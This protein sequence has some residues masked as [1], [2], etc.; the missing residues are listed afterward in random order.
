MKFPKQKFLQFC[1]RLVIDSK[2]QGLTPLKLNGAQRF[3]I[4]SMCASLEQ[5]VHKFVTLK[6][7]QFGAST[8]MLALDLFWQFYYQGM[9]GAIVVDKEKTR[10]Q[11]KS[12]LESYMLGLPREWRIPVRQHNRNQLVLQNRSRVAYLVAGGRQSG[13]LA[14]GAGLNFLHA[15]EVSS[16]SDEEGLA[17]LT[18]S[19]AEKHPNRLY[20]FESTARGFNIFYDMWQDALRSHSTKGIFIGWWL[21]EDYALDKDS[22]LFD[23]YW[24]GKLSQ[25]ERRWVK[26]VK[27]EHEFDIRPEQIAWYRW[28]LGEEIHDEKLMMQEFPWLPDQAFIL[29]GEQFFNTST[30]L[31][32]KKQIDVSP[33]PETFSYEIGPEFQNTQLHAARDGELKIWQQPA[34]DGYYAIGADPAYGGSESGDNFVIQ[35]LRCYADGVE[36]V[37]EYASRSGTM[38]G[39][40]WILAHLAGAY[41]NVHIIL[42]ITGPGNGVW[43]ELQTLPSKLAYQNASEAPVGQ[44]LNIFGNMSHYIYRRPDSMGGG[45]GFWH[46]QTTANNKQWSMHQ[47]RDA[48]ERKLLKVRSLD[49]IDEARYITQDGSSISGEGR[50]KDDRV[51]G[52]ALAVEAWVRA[53]QPMLQAQGRTRKVAGETAPDPTVGNLLVQGYLADLMAG[54]RPN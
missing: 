49:W 30:L 26:Q 32:I 27:V 39:F 9:Q 16:W 31:E 54:K 8:V 11:F 17:S 21:K 53:V 29:S 13:A 2:E 44:L 15:T 23:V 22:D 7:R 46:W 24:D 34:A 19:L 10:D 42:E 48:V 6:G 20:V 40:A 14:R 50:N 35:V 47:L 51:M 18:A 28:K 52:M 36:Q 3:L 37:A 43:Q 5:D 45:G 33:P 4:D 1:S 41:R 38:Y 12:T 25:E